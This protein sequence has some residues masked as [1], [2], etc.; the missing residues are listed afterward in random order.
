M[1]NTS[2]RARKLFLLLVAFLNFNAFSQNTFPGGIKDIVAAADNLQTKLPAEK[3][4]LHT[5][6][7]NYSIGDTLWFKA[8][9]L[10]AANLSSSEKSN[11]LFVEL[12][13]DS[14]EVI[15]RIS[16]PIN[17]GVG[18]AQI[19]LTKEI[20]HDGGYTL[21][22]Y[23][24][25]T[26]NFGIDYAFAKRF[27]MG[28]ANKDSWLVNSNVRINK[29]DGKDQL[30]ID[31][32]LM[33]INKIPIGLRKVEVRI[34]EADRTLYNKTMETPL[35]GK[36]AIKYNLKQKRDAGNMRLEIWNL[37]KGAD[38][39]FLRIPLTINRAEKIDLQF[40][41]EGGN[42]VVGLKSVV[43]FKAIAENGNGADVTGYIYDGKNN[44]ICSFASL[45]KGMGVFEFTP[46]FGEKYIARLNTPKDSKTTFNL[47]E[48][49]S[50]GTVLNIEN[51]ELS[52]SL[53][54]SINATNDI[55]ASANPLYLIGS[56]RGIVCFAQSVNLKNSKTAM[57]KSL[58]P[59][60]IVRF[61]LLNGHTPIN[62]RIAFIDHQ[63]N[64]EIKV[65]S[66][67]P[68]Y[69]KRDSVSLEIEVK[70]KNG[71]PV[72]SSLSLAVTDNSQVKSDSL[73]NFGITTNLLFCNDLKGFVEE[74]GFYMNRKNKIAWL[75]LD[76][77]M[78]TQGWTGF[79]WKTVFTPIEQPKFDGIISKETRNLPSM[80]FPET[81]TL[82]LTPWFINGDNTTFNYAQNL[83]KFV[84]YER[85]STGN[86]LKEV[87][88]T[89]K[90]IDYT[91]YNLNGFGQAD[92]VLDSAAISRSEAIGMYQLLKQKIPGLKIEWEHLS[93]ENKGGYSLKI[94][95]RWVRLR[96]DGA[97]D[98]FLTLGKTPQN[99]KDR[100]N[101][102]KMFS[103][104]SIE[105]MYTQKYLWKYYPPVPPEPF[106]RGRQA[107]IAESYAKSPLPTPPPTAEIKLY[108]IIQL[109]SSLKKRMDPNPLSIMPAQQFYQPK[110]KNG[111][112]TAPFDARPV[113]HWEPDIITDKNG[114][115]TVSFYSADIPGSYSISIEGSNLDGNIG[116][117]R[118]K[119]KVMEK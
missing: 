82:Q 66:N 69:G 56:S 86:M 114:R 44:V 100:L 73:G 117:H 47:P 15:R 80:T 30:L 89:S 110:Y 43:G 53:K 67:K 88:I 14:T 87:K 105:I 17:N 13:D 104:N 42:L 12:H 92:I 34:M 45:H 6:K 85:T 63:D 54:L 71:K 36:L 74:P 18:Y 95:D 79:D 109:T 116:T 21:K 1:K 5:D 64:L 59:S 25:W 46:K 102:F 83:N 2:Q 72:M 77:L 84:D 33:D 60:G 26:Q 106:Q 99:L 78:L 28:S 61:T 62:E 91:A 9:V 35:N 58:F 107:K 98:N 39:V 16:I 119:L 32:S 55:K 113:I 37:K 115:A 93:V 40:L 31:I 118:S 108:A 65:L 19:P 29:I 52:D 57:A 51:Q 3:V 70:D 41:P 50:S 48:I 4:Y 103:I 81:K 8:Y 96:F 111:S 101:E 20:F 23:T 90:K 27:Y 49:A 10:D 11:L 22:A 68:S 38:K 94:G 7:H 97:K 112:N 24:N 75:A 76:H